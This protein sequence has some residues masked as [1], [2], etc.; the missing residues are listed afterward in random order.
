MTDAFGIEPDRVERPSRNSFAITPH[1]TNPVI[2]LP[3]G[4]Y[5]GGAGNITLRTVDGTAD[6]VLN[7]VPAGVILPVRAQFVRATGTTATGLVGLA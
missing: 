4:I 2:P 3:K 1:A 6:V 5:V 7:N